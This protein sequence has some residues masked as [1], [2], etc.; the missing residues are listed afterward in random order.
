MKTAVAQSA[1]QAPLQDADEI[2][3]VRELLDA[4]IQTRYYTEQGPTT[5]LL[6]R[7]MP[8]DI[9]SS[10]Y[11]LTIQPWDLWAGAVL[12]QPKTPPHPEIG[13]R[14]SARTISTWYER[15]SGRP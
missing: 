5:R 13:L 14:C 3:V 7:L 9:A 11:A 2:S 4:V 1:P 12:R 6:R 8:D 15:P 10:V